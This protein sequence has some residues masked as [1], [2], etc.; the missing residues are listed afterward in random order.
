MTGRTPA[1]EDVATISARLREIQTERMAR[2]AGCACEQ[3]DTG[4]NLLHAPQCP[5]RAQPPSQIELATEALWR[6]RARLR[7]RD[8]AE[9]YVEHI[10]R[11]V[12][13]KAAR[14]RVV[15]P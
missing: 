1:C 2:I 9:R 3:R 15:P 8:A 14:G 7:T 10:E 6:A 5:L 11:A 4:G 13:A 12:E